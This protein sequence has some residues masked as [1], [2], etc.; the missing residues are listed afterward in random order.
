VVDQRLENRGGRR[1][2]FVG[3]LETS[4]E[5]VRQQT[6]AKNKGNAAL[7]T[8]REVHYFVDIPLVAC[9]RIFVDHADDTP[10]HIFPTGKKSKIYDILK[11]I[12]ISEVGVSLLPMKDMNR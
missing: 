1:T 7:R 9:S 12:I 5:K 8:S 10:N 4:N 11:C 2:P 3:M 6:T